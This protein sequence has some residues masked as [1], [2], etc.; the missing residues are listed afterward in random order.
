MGYRSHPGPR[1]GIR[2]CISPVGV[3]ADY[4]TRV[5]LL[6]RIRD[7][8]RRAPFGRV[9]GWDETGDRVWVEWLDPDDRKRKRRRI[10]SSVRAQFLRAACP[11]CRE[12][13]DAADFEHAHT[14]DGSDDTFTPRG[15][16]PGPD[17]RYPHASGTIAGPG[18]PPFFPPAAGM[19]DALRIR[20]PSINQQTAGVTPADFALQ[21]DPT[22][23]ELFAQA[24][25]QLG[26]AMAREVRRGL[27][28]PQ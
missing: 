7:P 25:R 24:Q 27:R 11:I 1:A 26:A 8:K 21:P 18:L 16:R 14:V 3:H 15:V 2:P 5:V 12:P 4:M 20:N 6:P 13:F 10:T 19:A 17:R 28:R 23:A 22:A 9:V